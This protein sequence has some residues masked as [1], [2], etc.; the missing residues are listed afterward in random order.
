MNKKKLAISLG[1]AL[2]AIAIFDLSWIDTELS[3][4]V[5]SVYESLVRL[6]VW[7]VC[8]GFFYKSL[9]APITTYWWVLPSVLILLYRIFPMLFAF[10]TWSARGFAP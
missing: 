1:V 5:S 6:F 3:Y 8:F 10:A 7:V 4:Q 2:Y 9:S